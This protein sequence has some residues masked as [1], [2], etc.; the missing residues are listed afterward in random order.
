M[1]TVI[2]TEK[3]VDKHLAFYNKYEKMC[4]FHKKKIYN[5]YEKMCQ[6]YTFLIIICT[7][8]ILIRR[9]SDDFIHESLWFS[10]LY[11]TFWALQIC[12]ISLFTHNAEISSILYST[13]WVQPG[14]I[15]LPKSHEALMKII[16]ESCKLNS[17]DW[18]FIP[19]NIWLCT[20]TRKYCT[21]MCTECAH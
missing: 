12:I 20:S 7:Q 14:F 3:L 6:F 21:C 1:H 19:E 11:Q 15:L 5:K 16:I 18:W 17:Q 10:G 2:S 9:S 4:Q 13:W 8:P